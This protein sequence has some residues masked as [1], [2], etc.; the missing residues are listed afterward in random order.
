MYERII[1]DRANIVYKRGERTS[2]VKGKVLSYDESIKTLCIHDEKEDTEFY[3][4]VTEIIELR[5][6]NG[7]P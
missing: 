6:L 4:N 1:G 2:Y 3:I 7:D 5:I